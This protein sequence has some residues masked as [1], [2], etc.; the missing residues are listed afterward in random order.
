MACGSAGAQ[1]P[2]RRV[3]AASRQEEEAQALR[4]EASWEMQGAACCRS[5]A[6]KAEEGPEAAVSLEVRYNTSV[7]D[8]V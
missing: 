1:E 3:R 2:A 6:A 8:I 5:E 4:E 7:P